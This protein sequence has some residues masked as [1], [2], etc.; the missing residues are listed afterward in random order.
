MFLAV[1]WT[2]GP[3]AALWRLRFHTY[4]KALYY[5]LLNRGQDQWMIELMDSP[6][7]RLY[8]PDVSITSWRKWC[9]EHA[10]PER[11]ASAVAVPL[12]Q[13]AAAY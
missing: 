12:G 4:V 13:P 6:P 7:E 10:R 5:G 11:T 2:S 9:H 3:D 8:R 1:R